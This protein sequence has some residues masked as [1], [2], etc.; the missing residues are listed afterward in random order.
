MNFALNRIALAASISL[1]SVPGI[2]GAFADCPADHIYDGYTCDEQKG[3][4]KNG[5]HFRIT[6]PS[7]WD[8]DLVIVNHGF[9]L[10]DRKI[11]PHETCSNDS[12]QACAA[13]V[14]CGSGNFCN[15]ISYMLL[16]EILLPM[17][18]AIA[19]P[20]YSTSGWAP[21]ES[22]KDIKDI[23]KYI[24]KESGYGDQLERV[25]VTGFSGGGAVT[26][27]AMLKLKI[28]GAIPLCAAAGGGLPTWDVAMDVRL[29]YDFLCDDVPGAKFQSAPDQGEVNSNN[30]SNDAINMALTVDTCLGVIG[31]A[32]HTPEM[33][34]RLADFLALTA[35]DGGAGNVATAM[36]F[37]TLGLGDFVRDPERLKG[38]LIGLNDTL[39]Y[40]TIG[41]GG[42]LAASFDAGVE[43][44][45]F[46]K[47]R[48]K[49][50]KAFNPIFTKGKG[51]KIEYPIL[52]MAGAADWLVIPEFQRVLTTGL[53][54]GGKAY[55]QT[56]IDTFGHCVFSEEETRAVFN[57]F[58]DW[59]GPLD[60]PYGTQ[61]TAED[62]AAECLAVGGIEGDTCNF[63]SAFVPGAVFDR[64][65]PRADWPL[66]A[67]H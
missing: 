45:V 47:G 54:D 42:P 34:T 60:G 38:K 14:D 27:D 4:G 9:D 51:K 44:L 21:F 19:A 26:V 10:N 2:A 50:A 53:T 61:P 55:T 12:N 46:G 5:G 23:L 39:D 56:W 64:I 30:S 24:K 7:N 59:L 20:T 35:F 41:V 66:A 32:P 57:S 67:T 43:R 36:G 62:V 16:D 3:A 17:G 58:F 48:K 11:R 65:P 31:F 13:D 33:D 63:N 25:I 6:F 1:L 52:S 18:K 15:N 22:A 40:S 8:G 29:V 37:A 28:D 49:L